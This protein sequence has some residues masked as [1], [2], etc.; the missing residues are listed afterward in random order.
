MDAISGTLLAGSV[1]EVACVGEH[2]I[3]GAEEA[4]FFAERA[5][6]TILDPKTRAPMA[7]EQCWE[8]FCR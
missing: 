4:I 8:C 1:V 6:L 3:M 5:V 2:F 7:L